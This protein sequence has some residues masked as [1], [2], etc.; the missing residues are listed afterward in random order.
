MTGILNE[1]GVLERPDPRQLMARLAAAIMIA[2]GRITESE[3]SAV[4]R[5]KELGLGALEPRVQAEIERATREPIDLV[6]TIAELGRV[7]PQSAA[8][9]VAGLAH[10]AGSDGDLSARELQVL[11]A[12]GEGLGLSA[13]DT[14][15]VI[16]SAVEDEMGGALAA[17]SRDGARSAV[18]PTSAAAAAA[19]APAPAPA[20][21][22]AETEIG[23]ALR[24]L[25]LAPS[26]SIAQ[27]DAAYAGLVRRYNPAA[28]LELGP[29]FAVLA[30]Q[31]L[32]TATAA[33]VAVRDALIPR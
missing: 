24:V 32:N 8:V 2:D 6:A 29:E 28:V 21:S 15:D 17:G 5:F 9:L 10:I 3:V 23:W 11:T 13:L 19:P 18:P 31:K 7:A 25:G 1:E 14:A 27:A 26:G 30:V 4:A 16:R 33:Y 12:I 22:A 20:P